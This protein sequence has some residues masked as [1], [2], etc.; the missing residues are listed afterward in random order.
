MASRTTL[1]SQ[2][3]P[4][5]TQRSGRGARHASRTGP[6]RDGRRGLP[7]A[8]PRTG[9]NYRAYGRGHLNRL[10]FV[11]R[12]RELGFTLE[13]VRDL[14]GLAEEGDRDCRALDQLA[15]EHLA[16]VERKIAD[17]ERLAEE[18]RR[19]SSRCQ[20]G[21]IAECQIIEALSP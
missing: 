9:G 6:R 17:L 14:L 3:P 1:L 20:G 13:Q 4:S 11:R 2:F 12:C 18:L 15:R 16:A 8:P 10:S 19:L 7:P 5:A 21:T